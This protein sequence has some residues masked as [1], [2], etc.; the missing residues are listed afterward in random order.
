[1]GK[2][3]KDQVLGVIV[4]VIAA[5]F[6]YHTFQLAPTDLVGDPGP[7]MFPLAGCLIMAIFAIVVIVHP[8]KDNGK[9]YLTKKQWM[10]ALL[11][12]AVYAL[13][14][15][16]LWLLGFVIANLI[17]LTIVSFMFSYVTEPD[18]P[19]GRRILK[20]IIYAVVVGAALWL[21]YDLAL[22][23]QLPRSVLMD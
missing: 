20:S 23:A 3:K 12:F 14:V 7:R 19:L 21:L 6:A 5:F 4:L 17:A 2:L 11:L 13:Y 16:L 9:V 8:E 1:M 22:E 15:F 18:K 10:Y